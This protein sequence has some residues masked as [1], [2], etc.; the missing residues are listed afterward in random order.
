[1]QYKFLS[2]Q[3]YVDYAGC[4]EME[5]K[6]LRPYAVVLVRVIGLDFAIPFR[7]NIKH[8]YVFWTDKANNCGLDYSKAVVVDLQRHI[9]HQRKPVIRKLEFK[10][11]L[12]QDAK[13]EAGLLRYI[14]L[15]KKACF[16]PDNPR[17]RN[18]V[19]YSTLKYFHDELGLAA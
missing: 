19:N 16:A 5:Q 12:R 4:S 3:F 7:S 2:E 9:D 17:N 8:S 11:L 14:N 18:I 6:P 1:M 10:A 15:Y 13:V